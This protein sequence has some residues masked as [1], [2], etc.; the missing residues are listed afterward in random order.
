MTKQCV[1]DLS[2]CLSIY[3]SAAAKQDNKPKPAAK[4]KFG[5]YD[6]LFRG[7]WFDCSDLM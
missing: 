7:L 3:F 4:K 6:S 5:K 2:Y 1:V